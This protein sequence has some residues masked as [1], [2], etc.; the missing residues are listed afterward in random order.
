MRD[1]FVIWR[2]ETLGNFSFGLF[3]G[4]LQPFYRVGPK[5]FRPVSVEGTFCIMGFSNQRFGS[6]HLVA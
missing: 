1:S 4:C 6:A 3:V 2:A 5:R